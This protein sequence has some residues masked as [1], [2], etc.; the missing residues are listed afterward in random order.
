MKNLFEQLHPLLR[1]ALANIGITEPTHAQRATL[2]H[3]KEKREHFVLVS[4]TG[5]GKTEAAMIP[6]LN[7]ILSEGREE[8]R[9]KG[10]VVLYITPLRALNR[11]M[12]GR[13]F[14]LCE[15][16][17]LSVGIRHGDTTQNERRKQLKNPP[18]ILITTPETLQIALVSPKFR[19]HL[20]SV[21]YT[22]ID[23]IHELAESK[24]GSQLIVGLERLRKI[25]QRE[26]LR[27]G[28]SA[29]VRNPSEIGQF[30]VGTNREFHILNTTQDLPPNIHVIFPK[31]KEEDE[32]IANKANC[33]LEAAAR[34]RILM[35][36]VKK[37]DSVLV[38][39]NTRQF[40]EILG[41][42]LLL[43]NPEF[44]F[45]V[46][47]GSL[48]KEHRISAETSFKKKSVNC[49]IC[50][51]SLELGIDIGHVDAVIQFMSPR[52]VSPLLQRV[53]RS[54]H[55][56]GRQ[57]IG[58]IISVSEE[59]ALESAIIS[60]KA[61]NG[62]SEKIV[63]WERPLD[64]L[65]HQLVG[66]VQ[67]Y[68]RMSLMETLELIRRAYAFRKL[69]M[70]KLLEVAEL[71]DELRVLRTDGFEIRRSSRTREFY[72]ES[73][74]MIV[75]TRK[76]EAWEATEKRLIALLDDKFVESKIDVGDIIVVKG[77]LWKV[78]EITD[79]RVNLV[80]APPTVQSVIPSW[81]G[82]LIPI[83]YEVARDIADVTYDLLSG[84][85]SPKYQALSLS[86]EAREQIE[87]FFTKAR[88]GFKTHYPRSDRLVIE[89]IGPVLV[90][91]SYLGSKGNETLGRLLASVLMAK[92]KQSV[93]IATDAYRVIIES[94][95]K[96]TAKEIHDTLVQIKPEHAS[97][98]LRVATLQSDLFLV[99]LK[100]VAQ[101]M[102][103]IEKKAEIN[104]RKLHFLADKYKSTVIGEEAYHE[105][106]HGYYDLR[107][108]QWWLAQLQENR[109][110]ILTIFSKINEPTLLAN[111]GLK[112]GLYEDFIK[113]QKPTRE[114]VKI[115]KKRLLNVRLRLVCMY[116]GNF[117]AT[118]TVA[119]IR[120]PIKCPKC[121][122]SMVA[123]VHEAE[124]EMIAVIR[125]NLRREELDKGEKRML[126]RALQS[127]NL[128]QQAGHRAA[129]A[130]AARGVGPETA[131][132]VL[133]TTINDSEEHFILKLIEAEA[134]YARTRPFWD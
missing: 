67:E 37:H 69:E 111:E 27:I 82:E 53:G 125:K 98:L 99:A 80:A 107:T 12:F 129:I 36:I 58:Y 88:E 17:G 78:V 100:A 83:P 116:C 4:E 130:L 20:R 48:A 95:Q 47:H 118:R 11:D 61:V 132:R 65:A 5:S 46:H 38:F 55:Q 103:L 57:S 77:S 109:V 23:E 33:S 40:A 59:D 18:D 110:Q 89:K 131:S 52:Q 96:I 120:P 92:Y 124:K 26:F 76:Y 122:S 126:K 64:V 79:D 6:V 86:N 74:S 63:P 90:L 15:T 133:Q 8:K 119:T 29:T 42:R 24:R 10:I 115:V 84:V 14:S 54:R 106:E 70:E 72:F 60:N 117:N 9:Q 30:L 81:V 71:L 68:G 7:E 41:N 45:T 62:E 66:L 123:A 13:L 104:K 39:T 112:R 75:D 16:L 3:F 127:A 35:E 25:T 105:I 44:T 113:P 19:E 22:I 91:H 34:L 114:I 85:T 87:K 121:N 51:S 28:L 101:R 93:S 43:L 2:N 97:L 1:E 56:L 73:I 32:E 49:I 21:R 31:Q 134:E 128:L 108:I 94:A 102:G 50:T